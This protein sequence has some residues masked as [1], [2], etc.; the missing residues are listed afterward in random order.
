[1]GAK[2]TATPKKNPGTK[3]QPVQLHKTKNEMVALY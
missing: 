2:K 1:M 3:L